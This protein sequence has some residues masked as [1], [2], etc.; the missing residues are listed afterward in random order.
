M[1]NYPIIHKIQA[2]GL[3]KDVENVVVRAFNKM[4]DYE[5]PDECLSIS[6]SLC[7]AIEYLG[8]NPRLCIGKF[9]VDNHDFYHAWSELEGRVIDIAIYGNSAFSVMW[10]DE[11]IEPQVNIDYA[12]TDVKYEPFVF[13][14]DFP[15]SQ[16]SMM[17]GKTFFYY[18]NS[19]PKRNAIWNLILSYLDTSSAQVLSCIKEQSQKHI[20]GE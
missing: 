8:Y 17:M 11:I 13:D 5:E 10:Q 3:P 14:E 19:A 4:N 20:I 2:A 9:W 15:F 1:R 6:I 16:I 7:L 12:N 18:C